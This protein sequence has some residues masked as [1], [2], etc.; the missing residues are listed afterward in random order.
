[1][2]FLRQALWMQVSLCIATSVFTADNVWTADTLRCNGESQLQGAIC[3]SQC[4]IIQPSEAKA[5][6]DLFDFFFFFSAEKRL[7]KEDYRR[8]NR[9]QLYLISSLYCPNSFRQWSGFHAV[10]KIN[11]VP[12]IKKMLMLFLK[13][14]FHCIFG[15]IGKYIIMKFLNLYIL[16]FTTWKI[17]QVIVLSN[18]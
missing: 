18:F 8:I 4:K 16:E 14:H 3:R 17:S 7:S 13:G 10:H 2:I 5:E 12:L 11:I 1:M 15:N 9:F 6:T